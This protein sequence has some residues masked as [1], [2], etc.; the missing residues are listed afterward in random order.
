MAMRWPEAAVPGDIH[1]VALGLEIVDEIR[2]LVQVIL[3][4]ED[5][6][7]RIHGSGNKLRD[8]ARDYPLLVSEQSENANPV[9]ATTGQGYTK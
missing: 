1:Q 5:A 9:P 8:V 2:R 6:R 7:G 4:D 3:D